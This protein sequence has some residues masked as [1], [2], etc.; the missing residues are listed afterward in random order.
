[1]PVRCLL[2]LTVGVGIWKAEGSLCEPSRVVWSETKIANFFSG[3]CVTFVLP[4]P[5]IAFLNFEQ[6]HGAFEIGL[7]VL[8]SLVVLAVF[9]CPFVERV[10]KRN[11]AVREQ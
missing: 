3:L 9:G 10:G 1:M 4:N 11:V 8:G 6:Y 2:V 7:A 5:Y